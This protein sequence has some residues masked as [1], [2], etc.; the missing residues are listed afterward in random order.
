M[1]PEDS[2]LQELEQLSVR[3][4]QLCVDNDITFVACYSYKERTNETESKEFRY[5]SAYMDEEKGV[6]SSSVAAACEILQLKSVPRK[7]I[8]MLE[9]LNDLQGKVRKVISDSDNVMH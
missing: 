3:M 9:V 7:Y 4:H 5:T 2:V 6:F 8:L 1:K